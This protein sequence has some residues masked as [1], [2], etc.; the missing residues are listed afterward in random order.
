MRG[1]LSGI[2]HLPNML[3]KRRAIQAARKVDDAYLLSILKPLDADKR[4]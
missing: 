4:G 1:M 3:N 2:I